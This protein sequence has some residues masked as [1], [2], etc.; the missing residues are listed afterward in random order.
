M[1][2][3]QVTPEIDSSSQEI[4]TQS[5][6]TGVSQGFPP[7]MADAVNSIPVEIHKAILGQLAPPIMGP[8]NIPLSKENIERIIDNECVKENHSFQLEKQKL[9]TASIIAILF[10]VGIFALLGGALYL[11]KEQLIWNIIVGFM[12][13]IAGRGS[14]GLGFISQDSP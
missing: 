9:R 7:Q 2:K 13:F 3:E 4:E 11:G 8:P 1:S 12:C 14:K 5:Q 6:G 10:I